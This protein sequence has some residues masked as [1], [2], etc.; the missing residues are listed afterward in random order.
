MPDSPSLSPPASPA[1]IYD[2]HFVP[3]LFGPWGARLAELAELRP[4][5]TVLDVACGTGALTFAALE[6][7][8]VDGRVVGLDPNEEML[9]VARSKGAAVEWRTGRAEAVPFPD[10]TFDR[11]VSQFGFM[12]FEEPVKALQEMFRV[13]AP[14]GR[15]VVAVCDGLDHSPGYAVLTELLHRL[16]GPAV[17]EAFRAPFGLGDRDRLRG[18]AREAELT[19]CEVRRV[20]G[21]V[22]FDS[23]R[24]LISTERA[25]VWTLGGLLD[26]EQFDR[27]QAAAEE[28]LAPFTRP[29]GQVELGMP[30][31][32]LLAEKPAGEAGR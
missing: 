23:I 12:F 24:A 29:G 22:R 10:A 6:R 14:G 2:E 3:A 25:C 1:E 32:C 13:L 7:V 30:T 26:E 28:S 19:G 27:L 11:V 5:H 16:F 21:T 20:D 17:A 15:S 8:G 9:A 18:L 4:G 31:L